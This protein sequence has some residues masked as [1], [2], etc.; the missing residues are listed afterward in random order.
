MPPPVCFW[1]QIQKTG[2]QT[3]AGLGGVRGSAVSSGVLQ[4]LV[5]LRLSDP[6]GTP[7]QPRFL[8][9]SAVGTPFFSHSA[10][11]REHS[12][13][14]GEEPGGAGGGVWQGPWKE[15]AGLEPDFSKTAH[16]FTQPPPPGRD[17]G[18]SFLSPVGRKEAQML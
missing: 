18:L 5:S 8:F 2:G 17:S 6:A 12:L 10:G 13:P 7:K 3:C 1:A 9:P 15:V 11:M 16:S 14:D 4:F